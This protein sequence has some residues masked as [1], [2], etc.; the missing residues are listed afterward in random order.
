M[1]FSKRIPQFWVIDI[2]VISI[3]KYYNNCNDSKKQTKRNEIISFLSYTLGLEKKAA[4]IFQK[5][6]A[7]FLPSGT[8]SNLTASKF[9]L[10]YEEN[11]ISW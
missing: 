4:K 3:K 10:D 9:L 11:N 7:T 6:A 8:M 5:E 1:L 2:S